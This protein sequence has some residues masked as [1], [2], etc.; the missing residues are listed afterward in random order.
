MAVTA[1]ITNLA[2]CYIISVST[3][4]ITG[5]ESCAQG[6]GLGKG[7]A[8]INCLWASAECR[9]RVVV[10]ELDFRTCLA[11]PIGSWA[12]A[13][14]FSFSLSLSPSQFNVNIDKRLNKRPGKEVGEGK[15]V[16]VEVQNW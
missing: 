11:L 9:E 7:F 8:R 4:Q 14:Q 13:A 1:D 5:F 10:E 16:S 12:R 6:Q 15:V 3:N 2:D